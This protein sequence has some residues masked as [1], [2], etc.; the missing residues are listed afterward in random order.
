MLNHVEPGLTPLAIDCRPFGAFRSTFEVERSTFDIHHLP[1]LT[2]R[3][4]ICRSFGAF[5]RRSKMSVQRSTFII[6]QG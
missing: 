2:P 5:V 4:I 1:G 3:P 6:Y